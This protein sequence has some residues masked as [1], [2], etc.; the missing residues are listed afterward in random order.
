MTSQFLQDIKARD[1]KSA[2][3]FCLSIDSFDGFNLIPVSVQ[4]NGTIA[5]EVNILTVWRNQFGRSFLTEFDATDDRTAKWLTSTVCDDRT[6]ALF[7]LYQDGQREPVGVC[8]LAR[9]DWI[10]LHAEAELIV[11][12]GS[13]PPGLMKAAL[14]SLIGWAADNLGMVRASVRVLADNPAVNFYLAVGFALEKAV[15]LRKRGVGAETHWIE[16]PTIPTP[17]RQLLYMSLPATPHLKDLIT[18]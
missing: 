5:E 1:R 3:P 11:S 18:S 13:T 8:G 7:M 14:L 2:H 12:S 6:R 9:I 16:D 17:N 10:E 4:P 15:P